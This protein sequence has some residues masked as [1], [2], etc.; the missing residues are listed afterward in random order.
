MPDSV[1]TCDLVTLPYPT[2]F[3]LFR[4]AATPAP[5]LSITNRMLVIRWTDTSGRRRT[6]LF[7]PSDVDLGAQNDSRFLQFFP[8]SELTAHWISPGTRPTVSHGAIT[9]GTTITRQWS[10]S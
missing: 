3:G 4:A 10:A 2:K 1:V 9:H 6:L 8:S 5:F 7:E